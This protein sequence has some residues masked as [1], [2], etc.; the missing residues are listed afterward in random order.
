MVVIAV[1]KAYKESVNCR[2]EGQ[3]ANRERNHGDVKV[4]YIMMDESY[5]TISKGTRV[6]G[7][8]GIMIGNALWYPAWERSQLVE[9]ADLI[10]AKVAKLPHSVMVQ[11]PGTSD[12]KAE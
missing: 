11:Q 5:T 2:M 12:E 8:L 9:T 4:E 3:Y 7:W 10:A 1:S 6:D